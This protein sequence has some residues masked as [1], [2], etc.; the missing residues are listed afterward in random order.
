MEAMSGPRLRR[1]GWLT[2][3]LIVATPRAH[4]QPPEPQREAKEHYEA[5]LARYNLGEFDAAINEFKT[6]YTLSHAPR[7]LF[8]IAQAQRLKKD[9]AQA[10]YSYTTYLRL[11]PDAPNR[12]DVTA[13]IAELSRILAEKGTAEIPP[14]TPGQSPSA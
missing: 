8:N 1:G 11:V 6:A 2:V 7:L 5:G 9:Y 3:L 13:R 4:A 14:G 12:V 10:L